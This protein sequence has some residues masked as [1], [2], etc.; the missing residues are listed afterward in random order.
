MVPQSNG[1]MFLADER[2]LN[3]MEWFRSYNTFNFGRYQHE[4]KTPFGALYVLN[5]DVLAEGCSMTMEVEEDTYIILIP[6]VGAV[7]WKTIH[8][9]GGIAE[10]GQAQRLFS[11]KGTR[12][13]ITNPY[14]DTPV[15]YVQLWIKKQSGAQGVAHRSFSFSLEDANKNLL[16][17]AF[18]DADGLT[19]GVSFDG[20]ACSFKGF[21]AKF[22]GRAEAVHRLS[23]PHHGLF[24]FV[25]QG[26]FECQY[27]LLHAGDGLAL[28]EI[29]DAEVEMEALSPDAIMLLIEL[30]L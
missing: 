29:P 22:D 18:S 4:H 28:W 10:A 24:A 23:A 25:L 26:A 14:E 8:N 2:G 12:F 7:A 5:E 27:R 9:E 30:S 3:E 21:L 15:R 13:T 11:G 20:P 6:V 17:E 16:V 19:D 1:K